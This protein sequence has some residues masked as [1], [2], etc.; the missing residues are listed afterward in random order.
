MMAVKGGQLRRNIQRRGNRGYSNAYRFPNLV[1][2]W[3]RPNYNSAVGTFCNNIANDLPITVNDPSIELEMLFIDDLINEMYDTMDE[4]PHRAEHPKIGEVI[5]GVE[6]D[7]C[8]QMKFLILTT[9]IHFLS[10][11]NLVLFISV[12]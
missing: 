8:G 11:F 2:Q 12:D 10:R 4:K 3:V 7:G 1:G 5:D 6:Y 9:R